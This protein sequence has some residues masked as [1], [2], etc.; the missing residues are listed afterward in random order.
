MR[1]RV[2]ARQGAYRVE[3]LGP[4]GRAD[5]FRLHS[6]ENGE[7]WCC[8]T[9]WWTETWD[10]WGERTEAENRALRE[11]LFDRGEWDGYLLYAGDEPVGWCQAGPRDRLAKLVAQFG[12]PPDPGAWAVTCFVVAPPFRRRGAARALLRGVLRDLAERGAARVEAF[13]RPG[14]AE[15]GEM[16]TG[17]EALYLE[18]G[19][20][21]IA[22]SGGRVILGK[23]I[24]RP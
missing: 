18:A 19:F 22:R 12:R 15:P 7:G 14:A 1:E 3:R 11:S 20:T 6:P 16:W 2:A 9:A 23:E 4:S 17:P 13:P 8:C 10:G 21:P 24:A 5:F